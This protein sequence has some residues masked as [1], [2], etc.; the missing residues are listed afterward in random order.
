M[1]DALL[2]GQ[3]VDLV[4]RFKDYIKKGTGK[5]WDEIPDDIVQGFIQQ[6]TNEVEQRA[7]ERGADTLAF[8]TALS[9]SA[10]DIEKYGDEFKKDNLTRDA[11]AISSHALL[12]KINNKQEWEETMQVILDLRNTIQSVTSSTV[13]SFLYN[14]LKNL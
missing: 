1:A 9:M 3:E 7:V 14:A 4:N 2:N 6:Y 12:Q 5:S 8:F 13:K 11:E 10:D